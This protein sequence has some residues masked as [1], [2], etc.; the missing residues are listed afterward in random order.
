MGINPSVS[1]EG[2][3]GIEPKIHRRIITCERSQGVSCSGRKGGTIW[4]THEPMCFF[5]LCARV[6]SNT[7]CPRGSSDATR[8]Y[9]ANEGPKNSATVEPRPPPA[10]S[11]T[12]GM[13]GEGLSRSRSHSWL[14]TR[15]P[16]VMAQLVRAPLTCPSLIGQ[17]V[18]AFVL[19]GNFRPFFPT[20][21]HW[22]FCNFCLI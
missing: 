13:R 14:F 6:F 20:V 16:L 9:T 15:L 17:D 12:A 5:S 22:Q 19:S 1:W 4:F 11:P 10:A 3:L 7:A 18:M 21:S 2:D 8:T